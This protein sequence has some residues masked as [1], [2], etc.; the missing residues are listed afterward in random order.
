VDEYFGRRNEIALAD[1]LT[2][3]PGGFDVRIVPS[4][5][6]AVRQNRLVPRLWTKRIRPGEMEI[7]TEFLPGGSDVLAAEVRDRAAAVRSGH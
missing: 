5:P 1:V 2:V 4:E 7:S 3:T 6:S